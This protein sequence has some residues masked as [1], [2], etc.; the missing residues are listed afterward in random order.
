ME[1]FIEKYKINYD[2][3]NL[4]NR[5]INYLYYIV[6]IIVLLACISIR[7]YLIYVLILSLICFII[8]TLVHTNIYLNSLSKL[9]SSLK[10]DYD[11]YQETQQI[12]NS[13]CMQ[14]PKHKDRQI[15]LTLY[16]TSLACNESPEKLI[17]AFLIYQKELNS[18]NAK[19]IL[20]LLNI[21]FYK[22]FPL[23]TK[24]ETK[25]LQ[26][27]F[28]NN[29]KPDKVINKIKEAFD[30]K[31]YQQILD[32]LKEI[33]DV[34]FYE[35]RDFIEAVTK[36]QINKDK[37]I[38]DNYVE[39]KHVPIYNT[40]IK[41]LEHDEIKY[42]KKYIDLYQQLTKNQV[43]YNHIQSKK[44][45]KT[46][47][48]AII[49]FGIIIF[50]FN[51]AL[52]STSQTY[53]SMQEYVNEQYDDLDH[54]ETILEF[55]QNGWHIGLARS[56]QDF[57]S[58]GSTAEKIVSIM[59]TYHILSI[60]EEDGK[61]IDSYSNSQTIL[62]ESYIIARVMDNEGTVIVS[63]SPAKILYKGKDISVETKSYV[64]N[65][66][67]VGFVNGEFNESYLE[68]ESSQ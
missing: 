39:E 26:R 42:D 23:N 16:L 48:I 9:Y 18:N 8:F 31:D 65:D 15:Q 17:D 58:D 20:E 66:F 52:S 11:N 54:V 13:I 63:F 33:D 60:Y 29:N 43:Q 55:N 3:I 34:H 46:L 53:N 7:E 49:Y 67:T 57:D 62:T 38:L 35:F 40:V 56:N 25:K 50:I 45:R 41:I 44:V 37:Q 21:Y 27:L 32:L 5:I 14:F 64:E 28:S 1:N 68:I 36:Y 47:I 24:I 10:F 22:E 6:N 61:I 30:Q 19:A 4:K 59:P 12:L 2:K 51:Q